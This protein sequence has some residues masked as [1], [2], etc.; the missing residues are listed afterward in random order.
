MFA[1]VVFKNEG[2]PPEVLYIIFFSY[3][4]ELKRGDDLTLRSLW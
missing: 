1:E 2:L 4:I 3:S